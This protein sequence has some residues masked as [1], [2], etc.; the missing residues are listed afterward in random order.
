M[1]WLDGMAPQGRRQRIGGATLPAPARQKGPGTLIALHELSSYDTFGG[2]PYVLHVAG[3][4][5]VKLNYGG[6]NSFVG[7]DS[8]ATD[9]LHAKAFLVPASGIMTVPITV[10]EQL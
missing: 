7:P 8:S 2:S 4:L 6:S 1:P 9:F 3:P 5:L 10:V